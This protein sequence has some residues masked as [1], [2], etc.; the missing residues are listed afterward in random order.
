M[1]NFESY[2]WMICCHRCCEINM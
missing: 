1:E 2:N